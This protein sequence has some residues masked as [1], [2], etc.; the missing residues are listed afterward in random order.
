MVAALIEARITPYAERLKGTRLAALPMFARRLSAAAM[1]KRRP[2]GS[3]TVWTMSKVEA[4]AGFHYLTLFSHPDVPESFL[5]AAE[6]EAVREIALSLTQALLARPGKNKLTREAA[7]RWIK[8]SQRT[9]DL[10]EQDPVTVDPRFVRRLKRRVERE[11]ERARSA[12][13]SIPPAVLRLLSPPKI[14][15]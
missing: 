2:G 3:I 9:R 13:T 7:E 12:I 6:V 8:A 11:D 10:E 4:L 5:S 14:S 1:R 15:P